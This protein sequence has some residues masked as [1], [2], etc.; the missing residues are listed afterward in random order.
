M[1][2]LLKTRTILT[3]KQEIDVNH[4]HHQQHF[5]NLSGGQI[6]RLRNYSV[7]ESRNI[8][9]SCSLKQIHEIFHMCVRKNEC[10]IHCMILWQAKNDVFTWLEY[11]S[12]TFVRQ[13]TFKG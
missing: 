6:V 12:C 13:N 2:T 5:P 3:M 9:Y 11:N 10:Q 1:T 7:I 4:L 8:Y